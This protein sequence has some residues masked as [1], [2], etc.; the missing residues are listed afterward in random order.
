MG[1]EKFTNLDIS[2][3][4]D[5]DEVI[6]NLLNDALKSGDDKYFYKTLGHVVKAK[7][8]T[9]IAKKAGL[10]RE[11]LYKSLSEEGNPRFDTICRVLDALG[12][13]LDFKIAS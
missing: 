10:T 5:N 12:V 6:V 4:L 8:V 7:G 1:K 11:G 13:T 9:A 3:Y 2:D